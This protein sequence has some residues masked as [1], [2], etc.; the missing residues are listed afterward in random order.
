MTEYYHTRYSRLYTA[1]QSGQRLIL[2]CL[3]QK[4]SPAVTTFGI[5]S[6][7]DFYR[8]GKAQIPVWYFA[9]FWWFALFLLAVIRLTDA[10]N[11][12]WLLQQQLNLWNFCRMANLCPLGKKKCNGSNGNSDAG[13]NCDCGIISKFFLIHMPVGWKSQR[14]SHRSPWW[15]AI[16]IPAIWV[17]MD[18]EHAIYRRIFENGEYRYYIGRILFYMHIWY[19]AIEGTGGGRDIS[20][21]IIVYKQ[22]KSIERSIISIMVFKISIAVC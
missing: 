18:I 21:R 15:Y 11:F 19:S 16:C 10:T 12:E 7:F 14:K 6:V 2:F 5:L 20:F 17:I 22:S 9:V 13:L 4:V 3:S 1:L 8:W